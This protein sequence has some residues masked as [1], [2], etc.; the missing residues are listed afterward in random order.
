MTHS[1]DL[2]ATEFTSDR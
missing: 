1:V 2:P